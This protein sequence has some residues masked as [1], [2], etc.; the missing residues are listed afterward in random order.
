MTAREL[1]SARGVT[2]IELMVA[3]A[4]GAIILAAVFQVVQGQQTAFYQGHLQRAAQASARAALSFVEQRVALAGY[5]M[6]ASLAFD[7]DRYP[8]VPCPA[9][10]AGCPRDSVNG[11]DELVFYSRDPRFWVPDDYGLDPHGNAWRILNLAPAA[12]TVTI[13]GRAGD[14]FLPGR[15]LQAV[16]KGGGRYAYFTV[17]SLA[18]RKVGAGDGALTVALQPSVANDPFRRQEGATDGCFSGGQ[19]RLF[20]IDRFRFHVRPVPSASGYQPYLVL[21]TGLRTGGDDGEGDEIVVAE[22]VEVFQVGYV[23]TNAALP[24]R[25]TTPGTA[26]A[27]TPGDTGAT[28]GDGITTLQFPGAVAAGMTEYQPTSWYGRALGPPPHASRLTDHQANIRGVRI[29][30]VARGPEPDPRAA[31]TNVF[32]PILNMNA[33]PAWIAP[34]VPY[35]RST[36]ETTVAVRNMTAR[37]MTDF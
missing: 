20:L 34:A 2:L 14:R 5:G 7:F 35:A 29:A 32:S 19:A 30:I 22:G 37:A 6:D 25:G 10:A 11:N 8:A 23:M 3:A 13:A 18:E 17:A 36:V 31:T 33:L 9:E 24:P 21:D 4:V 28:A 1:R 16:C 12:N 26:V 15:I 27:F